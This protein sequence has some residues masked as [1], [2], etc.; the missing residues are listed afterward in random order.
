MRGRPGVGL[1]LAFHF[2][3]QDRLGACRQIRAPS[4]FQEGPVEELACTG[5]GASSGGRG[6]RGALER[7]KGGEK[8]ARGRG[9]G[10]EAELDADEERQ[11]SLAADEEVDEVAPSR[12]LGDGVSR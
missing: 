4:D 2:G 7:W 3:E 5:S 6:F 8:R 11:R 10:C 1:V 12:V 9:D